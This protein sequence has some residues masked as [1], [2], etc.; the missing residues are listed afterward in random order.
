MKHFLLKTAVGL[1]A[2]GWSLTA[3]AKTDL[4]PPEMERQVEAVAKQ[5]ELAR[6]QLQLVENQYTLREETSEADARL[7][8]F[9]DGEIQ[10]LLGDYSTAAVL[11]YDLVANKEFQRSTRY[12]DALFYLA[13]SLYQQKNFLGSRLYLRQLLQLQGEHYR[14]ALARYLEIAG[15]LNE[16]AGIDDFIA[17]A[18]KLEGNALPPELTYVWAKWTFRRQDL[19]VEDR[20]ARSRS[21]F[22]ALAADKAGPFHLQSAYYMGVGYVHLKQWEQALAQFQEVSQRP[23]R[24]DKEQT[25]KELAELSMGRVYFEMGKYDL[26]IDRYARIPQK[27]NSFPDSLYEIAWSFIRKGEL[28]KAKNATEVLLM[29]AEDS[30]L[31]PEA[32]ILQGTLLQKLQRYEDALKTYDQVINTY[33]PVRDDTFSLLSVDD[34]VQFYERQLAQNDKSFDV[35]QLL[36][37]IAQ[38]W[39]STREEIAEAIEITAAL[40][41]SNEGIEES[42]LIAERILRSLDERGLESFPVLQEGYTRADAVDTGLTR[43]EATLTGFEE[44]LVMAA[45]G[46][47]QQ[48]QLA[49]LKQQ[50]ADLQ[51]R[52]ETLPT[53]TEEVRARKERIQ[54]AIDGLDKQA[55]QSGIEIQSQMAQLTAIKKFVEDTRAQ[56]KD[57]AEVEKAFLERVSTE[58]RALEAMQLQVAELRAQLL[59]ERNNADK[60]VGGEGQLKKDYLALLEQERELLRQARSRLPGQTQRTLDRIDAVR[61]DIQPLRE[62]A[63]RSKA[64]VR[65]RVAVRAQRLREQVQLE[66]QFLD[67]YRTETVGVTQESRNLVGR[68]AYDSFKRV[69]QS[70]YNLV[71]KADVGVVDVS[72]QR[73]QDNTAQIQKLASQKDRELKQLDDEFKEVLKDVD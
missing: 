15:R 70:F 5:L 29:V 63:Q 61:G 37:P 66:Q 65:E 31:A 26:A 20:V 62:R 40:R 12:A 49:T 58:Q 14:E 4:S 43:A 44:Q 38:K 22:E 30:M 53:T 36:H 67:N 51:R 13:D 25:I 24:D 71:L 23:V 59:S 2:L 55:F 9:S 57:P 64:S 16:Y 60:A 54:L 32:T 28:E 18:R 27:S 73:K 48:K 41:A 56:R 10:Y 50:L 39:A 3:E 6:G 33:G 47:E 19:N 34:P 8:R 72:F 35:T 11:F 69:H 52:I 42:R 68:I 7:Q 1:V 17:Q 46:T 21:I 45:L